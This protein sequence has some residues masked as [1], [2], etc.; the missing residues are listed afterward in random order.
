MEGDERGLIQTHQVYVTRH[1]ARY[2]A[3]IQADFYTFFL[4]HQRDLLPPAEALLLESAHVCVFHTFGNLLMDPE[5]QALAQGL[6]TP[7][8]YVFAASG[9][10]RALGFGNWS[11][12]SLVPDQML[13]LQAPSDY[14]SLFFQ[15]LP[16][17]T[18]L[19]LFFMPGAAAAIMNLVYVAR[20]HEHPHLSYTSYAEMMLGNHGEIFHGE[21]VHAVHRGDPWSEC[22]G[23]RHVPAPSDEKASSHA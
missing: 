4:E 22:R 17:G 21:T 19:P 11:V 1:L 8:A 23:I 3:G 10:A 14:E 6:T 7:E 12:G 2:Y 13:T 5:I 20:I 15:V 16:R 9:V 18:S